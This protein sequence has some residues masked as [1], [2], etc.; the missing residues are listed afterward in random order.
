MGSRCY[1]ETQSFGRC[2]EG[3]SAPRGSVNHGDFGFG[4]YPAR[5]EACFGGT[6]AGDGDEFGEE[7][8]VVSS[9]EEF[10]LNSWDDFVKAECVKTFDVGEGCE[11][12]YRCP[13]PGRFAFEDILVRQNGV[14]MCT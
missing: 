9:C 11:D 10:E 7:V 3:F 6:F 8:A 13:V 12:K 2:S 4:E 5:K 1:D 14:L